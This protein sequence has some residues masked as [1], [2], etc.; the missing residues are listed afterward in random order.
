MTQPGQPEHPAPPGPPDDEEAP[1]G[2][3]DGLGRIKVK[4]GVVI[5][6]AVATAFLVNEG[7][8]LV[9]MPAPARVVLAT[10][11]ALSMVQVLSRGMTKPLRD[12]VAGAQRIAKGGYDLRVRAESRDEVGELARAFNAMAGDLAEV[13][14]QRRELVANVSHELRTPIAALRAVLENLVDGVS[15][16]DPQTLGTALA[17][18]ER[19]GRLVKQLLDL[20]RLES[21]A[22]LIQPET[23]ELADLCD[24]AVRESAL[25]RSEVEVR[26]DVPDHL[27]VRADPDLLAQALANLLDNAVRHS[28]E[29]G[30]VTLAAEPNG[31]G[32]RLTVTDEGPGIPPAERTH[33]FE[34]FSRLDAGRAEDLGGTGLGLAI[35]KE[36]VELHD[37]TIQVAD[38]RGT[39]TGT[40]C[41]MSIELPERILMSET[42]PSPAPA[43]EPQP[44][45]AA[46][47]Q[48]TPAEAAATPAP[49]AE[50]AAAVEPPT[51]APAT[52]PA[53][54][55]Q[56][57]PTGQPVPVAA[58][59]AASQPA[60]AQAFGPPPGPARA[61]QGTT[62]FP[63]PP[64]NYVPPPVFPRPKLPDSPKWLTWRS[65]AV[66]LV[67]AI[68]WPFTTPGIG[69]LLAT[70]AVGVAAAPA[71][72]KR[73]TPW[74]IGFAAISYGLVAVAVFRDAPWMVAPM[75][76][77]AAAFGALAVAGTG[78]HWL[79]I[80]KGWFSVPLAVLHLPWFL[81]GPMKRAFS[82]GKLAP[83]VVGTVV[84]VV[85][86]LVF[87]SL[88]A[89]ADVVFSSYV[90]V[91]WQAD[92][93]ETM[94]ARIFVF[95]FFALTLA[96]VVLVA[97]RP[98]AEPKPPK[99]GFRLSRAVWM[100]PLIALNALF[101]LFVIVQISVLFGGQRHVLETAGMTYAEYAR[102]GFFQLVWISVFVL[103]IV[104]V[105]AGML[106]FTGPDRWVAA[107]LLGLL[108]GW[109]LVVLA[110]AAQR[111][112]LYVDM[113]GWSRLRAEVAATIWWLA[114][115]FALV[116][117]AGGIRLLRK[118]SAD[119][120]PRAIVAL[121][122]AGLL[123][124]AGWNPDL[125]IAESSIEV[126]GVDRIDQSYLSGLGA[127][128]IPALDKLPEPVRSCVLREIMY[129][130]NLHDTGDQAT[131]WTSWNLAR[132]RGR[133][134]L[135][136]RPVDE[137][138]TCDYSSSEYTD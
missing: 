90:E 131:E 44:A 82:R 9:S 111:L 72:R 79:G 65:A 7:G 126:R 123:A 28:P 76:L 8:R 108:C 135:E 30:T 118:G 87:G 55:A 106:A 69:F 54:T 112:H 1:T 96:A 105:V 119:W 14:R 68:V 39:E 47:A 132:A 136:D 133:A 71:L 104:A 40:G 64:P 36:I 22:R 129:S 48:P 5:V 113:Y 27:A 34:R 19:L 114:V 56:P 24:Q 101:A 84:T 74:T 103:G 94:P 3:L 77:A 62:P 15:E 63:P 110:S 89:A 125:R 78:R 20:S 10:L 59:Q 29:G 17:Q 121:T 6:A 13:D 12:M 95:G 117:T 93:L 109:T 81:G 43:P 91:L 46:G 102:S 97:L 38:S 42:P 49:A 33:V 41:R 73:L 60:A 100:I 57:A 128:A 51:T 61:P 67:A 98:V 2:I 99:F 122:G 45:K 88:F 130:S 107:S 32:V 4:L 116:L 115:V 50:P 70:V 26:C 127:D 85:L 137:N 120:L 52:T 23:V 31:S 58:Q 86:L 21:G 16:P 92:W 53:P 11:L 25:G 80:V 75:V 134:I 18:T 35:T 138:V 124:F 83:A 37:G 66:G